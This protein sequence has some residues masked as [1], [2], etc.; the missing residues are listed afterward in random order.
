MLLTRFTNIFPSFS[1][2]HEQCALIDS[3]KSYVRYISHELRTPLNTAFLGLKLLTDDLKSSGNAVDIGRCE[4]LIDVNLSCKAALDILNDL[5]CFD[6][7]E[8]GILEVRKQN[9]Y[10]LPFIS[11]CVAM[12]NVQ[13][14]EIG[15]NL[16]MTN[17]FHAPDISPRNMVFP[18]HP[19]ETVFIDKFKMDQ[20]IRNL[21]SN[22]LKFTPRGGTVSVTVA[23]QPNTK[24]EEKKELSKSFTVVDQFDRMKRTTSSLFTNSSS[25]RIHSG[26]AEVEF[27]GNIISDE[28]VSY[29]KLVISVYDSGAGISKENQQRLFKDV[30]QFNPEI[31][32]AGGGSGLGLWITKGIVDLHSGEIDVQSEGEGLGSVFIVKLPMCRADS[33]FSVADSPMSSEVD[34]MERIERM[35]K[36]NRERRE[37]LMERGA[38]Y[39]GGLVH[40]MDR[41]LSKTR[42]DDLMP[43]SPYGPHRGV[44]IGL[45]GSHIGPHSGPHFSA[46]K[47]LNYDSARA[48]GTSTPNHPNR[49]GDSNRVSLDPNPNRAGDTGDRGD[50]G[51]VLCNPNPDHNLMRSDSGRV[52]GIKAAAGSND[53]YA[54]IAGIDSSISE[55][56]STYDSVPDASHVG[57]RYD[58][59]IVDDSYLNRK[60]L[61]KVLRGVGHH[62]EEAEDGLVAIAKVRES[63]LLAD[64]GI[65]KVYDA[66]LMDFVMPNMGGPQATKMIIDLGFE[67]PVFGVTGNALES[68]ILHFM[69]SGASKV[70]AKPLDFPQLEESLKATIDKKSVLSTLALVATV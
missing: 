34:R 33:F 58:L 12:F 45:H 6:K 11:N 43:P 29:G 19:S 54:S 46:I 59:L 16:S 15:V 17:P 38:S 26:E 28:T 56:S 2:V 7:L 69:E 65:G 52:T 25:T 48:S 39:S 24:V 49:S 66:I 70:F 10:I 14:R 37:S 23:Y 31:L 32:Q 44:D 30:V 3:K 5:L 20:V 8:S 53:S 18:I 21:I 22:A 41:G 27:G 68:D 60:M 63:M 13:A 42:C 64:S 57:P 67:G 4:T 9:M 55:T 62:C 47:S 51:R 35:D 50:S 40:S 61:C 1:F 36:E